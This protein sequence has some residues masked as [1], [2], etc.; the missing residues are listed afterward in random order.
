[1]KLLNFS[2]CILAARFYSLRS[3]LT[4]SGLYWSPNTLTLSSLYDRIFTLGWA[5]LSIFIP[6]KLIICLVYFRLCCPGCCLLFPLPPL[7]V[8]NLKVPS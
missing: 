4:F 7:S 1:M 6:L 2:N 3:R 5:K 8:L